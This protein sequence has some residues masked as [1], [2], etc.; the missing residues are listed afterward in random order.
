MPAGAWESAERLGGSMLAAMSDGDA[1]VVIEAPGLG[2]GFWAGGPSVVLDEHGYWLAYRLRRPVDQGR[3]Y[4]NVVAFSPDGL[5]F[6][7]VAWL[8]SVSFA[9]ASLERPAL[10]RLPDGSWRLYV[11]CST[12][13]SKHWWIEAVDAATPDRLASGRRRVVLAGS[14]RAAWKDPVVQVN[15]STWRMWVCRHPLDG[16]DDA[17]DRMSSWYAVSGDGLEWAMHAEALA[18]TPGTWDARG[19][20]IADVVRVGDRW[21]A[22]Y[23][24]RRSAEENW[25]ER[26]GIA[27]GPGPHVLTAI[28]GPVPDAAGQTVR[29]A[30]AVPTEAG[31]RLYFEASAAD[32]SHDL[33]TVL[34]PDSEPIAR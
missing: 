4:A 3:G 19:A 21:L 11:S 16:G 26:T 12:P 20:R 7:T 18:P 13:D 8:S 22:V 25:R 24:G 9:A 14:H 34:V 29:Y 1:K 31:L 23:D 30:C 33:R 10:V 15:G 32:G 6:D 28:D 17:A 27:L 5:Q 2:E